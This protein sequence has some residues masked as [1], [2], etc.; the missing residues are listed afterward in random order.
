M[1]IQLNER[2][3]TSCS[4]S[5][6]RLRLSCSVPSLP[7]S[8]SACS[9]G[10]DGCGGFR[11]NFILSPATLLMYLHVLFS[12]STSNASAQ[13]S[14]TRVQRTSS[15]TL[16]PCVY[17]NMNACTSTATP[18]L[19]NVNMKYTLNDRPFH[20]FMPTARAHTSHPLSFP[21]RRW[22]CFIHRHVRT[23]CGFSFKPFRF[24][25]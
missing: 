11:G 12:S 4:L 9:R 15:S 20:R 3:R 25:S 5:S 7:L 19:Y 23:Q 16:V 1:C 2:C 14:S 18:P 21:R 22:Q 6:Q 8:P 13:S 24:Q 17:K 10:G